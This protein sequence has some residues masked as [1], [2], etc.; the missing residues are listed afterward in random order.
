M[1]K[2]LV[3]DDDPVILN[4]VCTKLKNENFGEITTAGD[5]KDAVDLI[6]KNTYDLI[7]TDL[8]MPFQSGLDVIKHVRRVLKINTPIIVL[9]SEGLENIVMEAF[10]MGVNDFITKPFSSKE[11]IIRVKNILD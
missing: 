7:I 4:V 9:S 6:S 8:Q 10:D 5:G 1:R 3:C 2:I 11:L